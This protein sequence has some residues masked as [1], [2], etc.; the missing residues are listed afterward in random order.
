MARFDELYPPDLLD[1]LESLFPLEPT[2]ALCQELYKHCLQALRMEEPP[3]VYVM[4]GVYTC[5]AFATF[6]AGRPAMGLCLEAFDFRPQKHPR[7]LGL[8]PK[9]LPIWFAHEMAHCARLGWGSRSP[10]RKVLEE[11]GE[12]S[13]ELISGR[14]PLWEYLWFEGLAVAFSQHM[15]GASLHECLG[16]AEEELRFCREK[17][18]KLWQ[19]FL[20]D[21]DRTD[22]EAYAKWFEG[23]PFEPRVPPPRAGYYLGYQVVAAARQGAA[24]KADWAELCRAG[25]E[26]VLTFLAKA[27]RGRLG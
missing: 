14:I 25:P 5:N 13:W 9:T 11:A 4:V 8:A 10:L 2:R 24:G 12:F 19:E 23:F 17:E 22:L 16:F 7:S 27:P 21:K 6:V 20:A 15:T 3:E 18:E 26:E 1:S